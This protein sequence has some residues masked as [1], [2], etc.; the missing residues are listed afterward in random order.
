[1]FKIIYPN[2]YIKILKINIPTQVN[3]LNAF[4]LKILIYLLNSLAFQLNLDI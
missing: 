4:S 2:T 3:Y 1:M